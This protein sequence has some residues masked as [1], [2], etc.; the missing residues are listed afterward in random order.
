MS[1]SG[2]SDFAVTRDE[3]IKAALRKVNAITSGE[4]PSSQEI[5]DAAHTLNAMVKSLQATG[6]HV[7]TVSEAVLFPAAGQSRYGLG[8]GATDRIAGSIVET[9]ISSGEAPG[10]TTLSVDDTDDITVND[11]I[12]VQ[13]DDGTFQWSTVS[14]KTSS[15]VTIADA[16]T[17]SAAE[18]MKIFA[19]TSLIGRPLKIV[20]ARR[21][22]ILS[23]QETPIDVVPYLDYQALPDK[24]SAGPVSQI[25]Y[26]PQLGTGYLHVW[27][28]PHLVEDLIRFTWWRP[29]ED[30]D[31]SGDNPDLPQEWIAALEW[32]LALELAVEY[33]VSDQMYRRIE[34]AAF[35]HLGNVSDFDRE[36]GPIF[37]QPARR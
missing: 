5:S 15:T 8:G 11:N 32:N 14:G 20:A 2:S 27:Q 1:T 36:D 37:F 30:F 24:A 29:I 22:N 18:G 16:L 19:Y 28:V 35:R 6:L 26:S 33:P 7:W 17:D 9:A 21:Q 34:S 31:A 23:G 4:T 25:T 13:L 10:E 12:G 3:L